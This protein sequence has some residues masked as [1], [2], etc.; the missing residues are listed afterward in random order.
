M[1]TK[2]LFLGLLFGQL[3]LLPNCF[4]RLLCF[5]GKIITIMI[6]TKQMLVNWCCMCKHDVQSVNH[7]VHPHVAWQSERHDGFPSRLMREGGEQ[8]TDFMVN[9]YII[10]DVAYLEAKGIIDI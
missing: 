9:G 1:G 7:L 4:P 5:Q 3:R 2:Q 10:F 8:V 6:L